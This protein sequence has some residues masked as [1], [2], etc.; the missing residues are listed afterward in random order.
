VLFRSRVYLMAVEGDHLQEVTPPQRILLAPGPTALPPTVIQAL[1]AP[2]TGHKDPF[3]LSVMDETARLLR[4]V[5][6]TDNGT[7]MSLP[8]TGG[9][10][11]EA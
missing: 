5:F 11:M 6:Q 8:G 2:I 3:F 1:I 10:G 9:A 4:H 7:C